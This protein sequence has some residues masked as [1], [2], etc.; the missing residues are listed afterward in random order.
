MSH[1]N[2]QLSCEGMDAW[3]QETLHLIKVHSAWMKCIYMFGT[4]MH[5]YIYSQH[6]YQ[7][8]II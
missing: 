5:I 1:I 7:L 4:P 3:L 8:V 6:R 2:H